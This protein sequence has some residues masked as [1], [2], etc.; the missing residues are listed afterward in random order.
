MTHPSADDRGYAF[1]YFRWMCVTKNNAYFT[2][3][4]YWDHINGR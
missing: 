2:Y 1:A 3:F 4:R